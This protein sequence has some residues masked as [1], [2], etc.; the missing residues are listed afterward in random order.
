MFVWGV[1]PLS[2]GSFGGWNAPLSC[3]NINY[4]Y[5]S[6]MLLPYVTLYILINGFGLRAQFGAKNDS[7]YFPTLGV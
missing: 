4:V 7:H 2:Q 5:L 6:N 3:A 1:P